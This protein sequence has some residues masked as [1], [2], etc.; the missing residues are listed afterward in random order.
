MDIIINILADIADIF[1]DL[2]MNEIVD[3]FTRRGRKGK[4]SDNVG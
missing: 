2:W 1:V 3:R 4:A